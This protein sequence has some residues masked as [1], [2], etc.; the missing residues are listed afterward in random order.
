MKKKFCTN[1]LIEDS[2]VVVP[3]IVSLAPKSQPCF[4]QKNTTVIEK[5]MKWAPN[6]WEEM[7]SSDHAH[8]LL[9]NGYADIN[10]RNLDHD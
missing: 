9:P 4:R 1:E 2:L 7:E 5:S 3:Q 10:R 6:E 8:H